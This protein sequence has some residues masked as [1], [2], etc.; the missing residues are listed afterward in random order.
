MVQPV[1]DVRALGGRDGQIREQEDHENEDSQ[2]A[3]SQCRFTDAEFEAKTA[4]LQEHFADL[5]TSLLQ[6]RADWAFRG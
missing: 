2:M 6:G 4:A 1:S 3:L 5:S